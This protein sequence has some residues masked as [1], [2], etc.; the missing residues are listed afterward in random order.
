MQSRS[1]PAAA[2]SRKTPKTA[3]SSGLHAVGA[4]PGIAGSLAF[5]LQ[6]LPNP[7]R[8]APELLNQQYLYELKSSPQVELLRAGQNN[9]GAMKLAR[10]SVSFSSPSVSAPRTFNSVACLVWRT[11]QLQSN[12]N[13]LLDVLEPVGC[14]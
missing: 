9:D 1:F 12:E 10:G 4:E 14:P 8:F 2:T 3:S 13:P 5:N 7:S 6:A 11:G